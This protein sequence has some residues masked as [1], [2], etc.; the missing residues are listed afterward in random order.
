MY[1]QTI[2]AMKSDK[3]SL[4]SALYQLQQ[5]IAQVESRRQQLEL[6]NQD[7]SIKRQNLSGIH[8]LFITK[9]ASYRRIVFPSLSDSSVN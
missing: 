5:D 2:A 7:L 1:F 3:N 4:E 8:V 6:D 9:P